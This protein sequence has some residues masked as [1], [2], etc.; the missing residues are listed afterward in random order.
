MVTQS[1]IAGSNEPRLLYTISQTAYK[2]ACSPRF[3]NTLIRRDDL[4][5]IGTRRGRRIIAV[6]VDRYIERQRQLEAS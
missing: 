2:L 4:E 3:V 6:S 5:A 1:L